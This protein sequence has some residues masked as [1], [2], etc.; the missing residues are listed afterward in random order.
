MAF[1]KKHKIYDGDVS[2]GCMKLMKGQYNFL[3]ADS[4]DIPEIVELYHNLIGT[5]G[6]TWSMDY[7]SKESAEC[8]IQSKSLYVLKEK[9]KIIAVASVGSFDELTH[10][11][12]KP[13][14]PCE[15]ARIGVS[16]SMQRQ[17]IGTII[18]Q[19]VIAVMKEK[20]Y[21]GIRMIVSKTN[22]AALALYNKNGFE[23]CGETMMFDM[24]WYCCQ[25]KF[26][27]EV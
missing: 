15:L 21:D 4:E 6:C 26:V 18:L 11:Q 25:I 13:K 7:P 19:S 16:P 10:L 27:H 24:S 1:Y 12:W 2:I 23:I 9:D 20:G 5:P 8:D 17:G 22:P 14:N 3:L